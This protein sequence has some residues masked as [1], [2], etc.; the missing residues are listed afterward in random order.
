MIKVRTWFCAHASGWSG[1]SRDRRALGGPMC[2]V[3]RAIPDD[4]VHSTGHQETRQ[5]LTFHSSYFLL[6]RG[7]RMN[8]SCDDLQFQSHEM[9]HGE[10]TRAAPHTAIDGKPRIRNKENSHENGITRRSYHETL[11]RTCKTTF[12]LLYVD[13]NTNAIDQLRQRRSF[14]NLSHDQTVCC[15]A[16]IPRTRHYF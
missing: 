3:T 1:V 2:A 14:P 8:I 10:R 9:Q 6:C 11:R 5:A 16:S 12:R 4:T 15:D 13:R 7:S